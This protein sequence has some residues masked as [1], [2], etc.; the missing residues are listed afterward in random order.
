M[1]RRL[2]TKVD[3]MRLL[4]WT[5]KSYENLSKALSDMGY[6]AN[7]DTVRIMLKN[8]GYGLQ[9]NKKSLSLK[10]THTDRYEQFEYINKETKKALED[11]NLVL[12]I[13]AK[14]KE[15]IGNFKN[16]GKTYQPHKTPVEVLDHD[17]PIKELSKATPF[18]VYC[19]SNEILHVFGMISSKIPV[20]FSN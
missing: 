19:L 10:S 9:A 15:N 12:S 16:D 13:Y 18:G 7:K 14:K 8:M 11:G 3:P 4:L 6:S 2:T 20:G 5:N 1:I 17:F